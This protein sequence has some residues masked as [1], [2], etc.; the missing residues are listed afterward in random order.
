ML[1]LRESGCDRMGGRE[2]ARRESHR[3]GEPRQRESCRAR[4]AS[5]NADGH[6][7]GRGMGSLAARAVDPES[8][9]AITECLPRIGMG[10]K[11]R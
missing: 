6:Y 10:K 1:L 3:G 8:L 2:E 4:V 5:G 7:G 9:E 11:R